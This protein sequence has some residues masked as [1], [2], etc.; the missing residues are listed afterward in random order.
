MHIRQNFDPNP[1]L[2]NM[3]LDTIVRMAAKCLF[4]KPILDAVFVGGQDASHLS[5]SAHM[6]II[7]HPMFHFQNSSL[8]SAKNKTQNC[9]KKTDKTCQW[10][11]LF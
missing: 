11:Q 8:T 7:F 5:Y 3:N 9:A 1:N 10:Q 6:H 4:C 2:L